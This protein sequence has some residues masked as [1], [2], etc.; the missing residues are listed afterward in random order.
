MYNGF[1]NVCI[2]SWAFTPC[3]IEAVFAKSSDKI[4]SYHLFKTVK[5]SDLS[6]LYM[7]FRKFLY[8]NFVQGYESRA[9]ILQRGGKTGMIKPER[10]WQLPFSGKGFPEKLVWIT[11]SS[12]AIPKYQR[13]Q[14]DIVL[15]I[16][17]KV[18]LP[19]ERIPPESWLI[20]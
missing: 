9:E 6:N 17:R 12:A 2:L 14:K 3:Q 4:D 1:L 20:G 10:E 13:L 7:L 11:D 18:F 19:G 16:K 8:M 15:N 5:I